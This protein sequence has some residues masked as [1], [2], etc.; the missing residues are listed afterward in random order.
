MTVT[1]PVHRPSPPGVSGYL[2]AA[3]IRLAA[4]VRRLREIRLP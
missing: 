1:T 4:L 3:A 2:V